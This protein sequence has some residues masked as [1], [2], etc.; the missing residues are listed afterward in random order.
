MFKKIKRRRQEIERKQR[1]AQM[2][3]RWYRTVKWRQ[4]LK[5]SRTW[6]RAGLKG[7]RV[8]RCIGFLRPYVIAYL[9]AE[10]E[11]KMKVRRDFLRA[12][13][14]VFQRHLYIKACFI[15]FA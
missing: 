5:R 10:S 8:R 7:W 14:F 11:E 4:K 2:I 9:D 13:A 3:A 12:Y 15:A 1:A 6:L